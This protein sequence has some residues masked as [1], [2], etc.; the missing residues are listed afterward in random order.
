MQYV[1]LGAEDTCLKVY[2]YIGSRHP[3]LGCPGD[4]C[5]TC[6]YSFHRISFIFPLPDVELDL[7]REELHHHLPAADRPAVPVHGEG[8]RAGGPEQEDGLEPEEEGEDS[9]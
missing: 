3:S 2:Q 4:D 8:S 7:R 5:C 6:S 9:I 1:C